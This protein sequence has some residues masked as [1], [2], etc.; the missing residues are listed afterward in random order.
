MV[1]WLRFLQRVSEGLKTVEPDLQKRKRLAIELLRDLEG[2]KGHNVDEIGKALDEMGAE[3][4]VRRAEEKVG[5][6]RRRRTLIEEG[7]KEEAVAQ[8]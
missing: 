6:K 5:K 4:L 2:E 7:E 1:C 8:E 3:G